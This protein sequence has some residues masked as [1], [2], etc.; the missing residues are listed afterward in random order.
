MSRLEAPLLSAIE[1]A[2]HLAVFDVAEGPLGVDAAF[3]HAGVSACTELESRREAASELSLRKRGWTKSTRIWA[4]RLESAARFGASSF[5]EPLSKKLRTRSRKI[6]R[7]LGPLRECDAVG[8]L[9]CQEETGSGFARGYVAGLVQGERAALVAEAIAGLSEI[10]P[11][12]NLLE[13]IRARQEECH[14]FDSERDVAMAR[15]T[16]REAAVVVADSAEKASSE[17]VDSLHDIRIRIKRARYVCEWLTP[18]LGATA[19]A[20][21]YAWLYSA[22]SH[23]GR[24]SDATDALEVIESVTRRASS[25]A[26]TNLQELESHWRA[27]LQRAAIDAWAW[28]GRHGSLVTGSLEA[29]GDE[30]M[31]Q[32]VDRLVAE[33]SAAR[34]K[35]A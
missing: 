33:H 27:E 20:P 30:R 8:K 29:A 2:E 21:A 14:G 24:I 11:L 10:E 28:W 25:D 32:A 22:Q 4:R 23:F 19:C 13:R 26:R 3:V 34:V 7:L 12:G 5:G 35:R 17:D 15:A 1:A 16:L 18:T 6:R 9:L 31:T